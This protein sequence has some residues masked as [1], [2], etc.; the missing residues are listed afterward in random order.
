MLF[1]VNPLMSNMDY[2][3]D[4]RFWTLIVFIN[5]LSME[6]QRALG[7]HQ[8]YLNLCSEDEQ[9]SYRFR[10]TWGR[11]INDRIFV[12]G[13]NWPFKPDVSM[14][15][16]PLN[17][18]SATGGPRV[19]LISGLCPQPHYF[20]SDWF[21]N[22]SVMTATVTHN[23]STWAERCDSEWS[24]FFLKSERR[25]FHSLW[26]RSIMSTIQGQRCVI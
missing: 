8:K 21:W 6:G 16:L 1:C 24:E 13:W 15:D 4:V 10:T 22:R 19:S 7:F 12:F 17:Q 25:G 18:W 3:T 23:Q 9:R 2:F 5:L 20:D 26:E 11:V 14:C